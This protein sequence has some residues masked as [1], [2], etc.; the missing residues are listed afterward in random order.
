MQVSF[1]I[2]PYHCHRAR[3]F[4]QAVVTRFGAVRDVRTDPPV[5][6]GTAEAGVRSYD[7]GAPLGRLESGVYAAY[8][9]DPCR[10]RPS[11]P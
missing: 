11:V 1:S 6:V 9:P 4:S 7:P 3:E 2:A 8:L 5:M 10:A